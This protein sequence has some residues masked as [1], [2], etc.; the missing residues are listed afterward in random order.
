MTDYTDY[1]V[2]KATLP[3]GNVR[4]T[5]DNLL[6]KQIFDEVI[7]LLEE[8]NV[9]PVRLLQELQELKEDS[10]KSPKDFS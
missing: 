4:C 9:N 10:R 3:I 6:H 7:S 2:S 5:C 1:Y 8:R